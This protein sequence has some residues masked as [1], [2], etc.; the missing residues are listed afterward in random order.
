M[1]NLS[2]IKN[3]QEPLGAETFLNKR[4]PLQ[5]ATKEIERYRLHP[6]NDPFE[7]LNLERFLRSCIKEL[8]HE[9]LEILYEVQTKLFSRLR[10]EHDKNQDQN[11][12]SDWERTAIILLSSTEEKTQPEKEL[13]ESFF[14]YAFGNKRLIQKIRRHRPI[15]TS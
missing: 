13:I 11:Q 1:T 4:F 9:D 3:T 2:R 7:L 5:K 12:I 10:Q 15:I 14:Q 6:T 8:K